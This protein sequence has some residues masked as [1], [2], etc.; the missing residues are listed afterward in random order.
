MFIR[1]TR[2]IRV[3]KKIILENKEK[4]WSDYTKFIELAETSTGLSPAD[5]LERYEI[6][7]SELESN[8]YFEWIYENT[9]E[10][11]TITKIHNLLSNELFKN[12]ILRNEFHQKIGDLDTRMKKFLIASS[13]NDENWWVDFKED[14]I[15]WEKVKSEQKAE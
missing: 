15:D 4:Y 6:L 8:L 9:G 3:P 2:V 14:K 10:E 5:L 1:S 11:P 12:N 7:I 13:L